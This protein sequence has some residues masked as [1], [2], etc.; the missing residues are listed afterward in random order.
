M[1]PTRIL[2]GAFLLMV[3]NPNYF[4]VRRTEEKL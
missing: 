3:V 2:L 1:M 4:A